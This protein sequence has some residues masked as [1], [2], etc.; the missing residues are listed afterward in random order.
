[1]VTSPTKEIGVSGLRY[2]GG[3]I[4]EEMLRNLQGDKG[5][6][7]YAEMSDNDATVGA[8]L[9]A[10]TSLVRPVQWT[11]TAVDDSDDA[12]EA[13]A[14]VEGVMQDMEHTWADM[15][16]EALTMLTYG[17]APM[18]TVYKKRIGPF[19]SDPA[20]R[21]RFDDQKIGI[22][23]IALRAQTTI[24]EWEIDD[25]TGNMT[26]LFQRSD[27]Q[28]GSRRY[29]PADRLLLF[30]TTPVRGNPEGRSILRNAYRPWYFKKRMEEFEAIG[31]ERDL[32]GLPMMHLP[33]EWLSASATP[34]Q[35]T[36]VVNFQNML[37]EIR[38][39]EQAHVVIP[40]L[41]DSDGNQQ[42]KF[43]LIASSGTRAHDVSSII[44]RYS[45]DIATTVL[46]D[47]IFL[48]QDK[49]GSY[50]LSSDKTT[51]FATALGT[52]LSII[53]DVFNR[54]QLPRLWKLNGMDMEWMPN[55]EFGDLEK[56]DLAAISSF[57]DA[58]AA[59]GAQVFPD[60]EL[61]NHLRD[62]AGFPKLP[63]DSEGEERDLLGQGD[64]DNVLD[65]EPNDEMND[66]EKALLQKA[67]D[68][69]S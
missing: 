60:R 61:E 41:F 29:I 63:E 17:F 34:E 13:K 47:F 27:F 43:E 6:T 21:S 69:L 52:Y 3:R 14:F 64:E 54:F 68:A 30:R 51:L 65:F 37:A 31:V 20:K 28:A 49:V 39:N 56:P 50:S 53:R 66:L 45:S 35:K 5:R 32:V 15:I 59:N 18:E 42:I 38:L 48:G 24:D 46:A 58:M 26:G 2:S 33:S 22:Q 19:E 25:A 57:L 40:S 16:T 12:D 7:T 1:M 55:V 9:F 11:V 8:I 36:A 23:K 4:Y 10:M 44:R 62:K 67:K